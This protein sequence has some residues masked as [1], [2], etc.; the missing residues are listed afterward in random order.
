MARAVLLIAG[1]LSP[2]VICDAQPT[3]PECTGIMGWRSE[4]GNP[5][6]PWDGPTLLYNP[7]APGHK[8]EWYSGYGINNP[9]IFVLDNGTT[10]LAG[11]TCSGPE[12]PWVAKAPSW[13][14]P[15]ASIDNDS[16]PFPM[17]NAEDPF[18]WRDTRGNYHMLHHWQAG[19]HNRYYNGGHSFSRDALSWTFSNTSSYSKNI[20]WSKPLRSGDRWTVFERRERPGLL[21]DTS[22]KVPRYLF[23]AVMGDLHPGQHRGS[24]WL[25][26][27]PIRQIHPP[28]PAPA[29]GGGQ[30]VRDEDC[31]LNGVCSASQGCECDAQWDGP[32]CG[33]LALLPADPAG[34]YRRP[35]F[36]SWGGNPFFS[37]HDSKYHVF[38]VEMTNGC[39]IND[40][41]T[42]SQ[43]VHCESVT[44][45]G[46]Y[47]LAPLGGPTQQQQQQQTPSAPAPNHTV[48]LKP[49]AHAAHV[50]REREGKGALVMAVEGRD[51]VSYPHGVPEKVC[52]P[53]KHDIEGISP[54]DVQVMV[55]Q[56]VTSVALKTDETGFDVA[57]RA[58]L[59]V[60]RL[61]K[62]VLA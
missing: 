35:G 5:L 34:G 9:S 13:R 2:V 48:F 21:L 41:I 43:I 37:E 33:V 44:P 51:G 31:S 50:W 23:T 14:G 29:S 27:Q 6:G 7:S 53:D 26:S 58:K 16:Q 60:M 62:L 18:M 15:F 49:F 30:C 4:S 25:Q 47:T 20:T 11:R 10:I 24:S 32:D 19:D 55:V 57:G 8:K 52:T 42:N 59:R 56:N 38:T 40:Y 3:N 54:H 45:G 22:W 36:N 12:H 61:K 1:A 39:T 17:L 46:P 28:P